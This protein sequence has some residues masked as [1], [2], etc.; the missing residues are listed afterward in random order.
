MTTSTP[1]S[2]PCSS[3]GPHGLRSGDL[4]KL[5]NASLHVLRVEVLNVSTIALLRLRWY[6]RFLLWLR[7]KRVKV[8]QRA[9]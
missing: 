3:P 9:P 1:S 6:H 5:P 7:L 8:L 2:G 4:I